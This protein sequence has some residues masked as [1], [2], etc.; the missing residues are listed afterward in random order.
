MRFEDFFECFE[1]FGLL[2]IPVV[3]VDIICH[4]CVFLAVFV[5]KRAFFLYFQ[6]KTDFFEIGFDLS[7]QM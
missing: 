6:S 1:P 3:G 7:G 4:C 5:E 2:Q